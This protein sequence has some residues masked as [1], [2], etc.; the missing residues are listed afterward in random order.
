[1]S[2]VRHQKLLNKLI[3]TAVTGALLSLSLFTAPMADTTTKHAALPPTC[4]PNC[5]LHGG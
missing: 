2:L 1:M 3:V 5:G 4:R